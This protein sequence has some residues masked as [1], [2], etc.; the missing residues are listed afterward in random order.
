MLSVAFLGTSD[1][2]DDRVFGCGLENLLSL[3]LM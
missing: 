2:S 3:E 1:E